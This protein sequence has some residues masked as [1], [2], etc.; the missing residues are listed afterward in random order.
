RDHPDELPPAD[1]RLRHAAHQGRPVQERDHPLPQALRRPRGLSPPAR[2]RQLTPAP[3]GGLARKSAAAYRWPSNDSPAVPGLT[4]PTCRADLIRAC[5][6]I[7]SGPSLSC[8]QSS[9]GRKSLSATPQKEARKCRLKPLTRHR[10]IDLR[11]MHPSAGQPPSN[12][13]LLCAWSAFRDRGAPVGPANVSPS[14][15]SGPSASP[16]EIPQVR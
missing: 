15:Q 12:A 14:R 1:P 7:P 2:S 9:N 10:S 3:G 16:T 8:P 11:R 5:P 13:K 4:S 6:R